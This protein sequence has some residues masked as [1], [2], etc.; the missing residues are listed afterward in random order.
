MAEEKTELPEITEEKIDKAALPQG[1]RVE[2]EI[3]D[4]PT[5]VELDAEEVKELSPV[6]EEE[7]K[8]DFEPNEVVEERV[9]DS[10]EAEKRAALAQNRIDQAVKQSKDYA[11]RELQALQYAKELEQQNKELR[12]SQEKISVNYGNEFENRIDAQTSAAK[13][14]LKDATEQQDA[15]AMADAQ[16]LIAT[17]AA[18]RSRLEQYKQQLEAYQAQQKLMVEQQPTNAQDNFQDAAE[19]QYGAPS[20]KAQQWAQKNT[21]FGVDPILTNV[22]FGVHSQ[23]ESEGFDTESDQY[24][25]EIDKRLRQ[26]MPQKFNEQNVESDSKPVQTVASATRTSGRGRKQGN[27]VELSSSEQQ[28]AKRLGVPLKEYAKHKVRLQRS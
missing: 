3:S 17:A 6:T 20:E 8:E 18:D 21:W 24:Y 1:K 11:R 25:S 13:Q 28:L 7:V 14:A 16:A 2:E 10:T 23:L 4:E 22:A 27:R 12:Q 19:V 15:E 9:K 5:I 26:E